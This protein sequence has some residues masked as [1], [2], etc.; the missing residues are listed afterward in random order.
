MLQRR[1][2]SAGFVISIFIAIIG[3]VVVL[4]ARQYQSHDETRLSAAQGVSNTGLSPAVSRFRNLSLQ[5]EAAKLSR[6]LGQRF[7]GSESDV[8]VLIGEVITGETRVPVRVVR[9]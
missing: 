6:R 3:G 5:P 7:V 9:R 4:A 8:S 1:F 2:L